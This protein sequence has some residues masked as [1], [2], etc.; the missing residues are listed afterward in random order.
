M[1]FSV[2]VHAPAA[3]TLRNPYIYQ[4]G[5]RESNRESGHF[6][7]MNLLLLQKIEPR[8]CQIIENYK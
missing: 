8:I 6:W 3:L 1:E 7:K 4:I 5:G 2:Q